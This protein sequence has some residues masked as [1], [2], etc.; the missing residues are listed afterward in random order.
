[1][2]MN[3]VF[4]QEGRNS[5]K[6]RES[7]NLLAYQIS[8]N[9]DLQSKSNIIFIEK[10]INCGAY[11]LDVID[12]ISLELCCVLE[13]KRFGLISFVLSSSSHMDFLKVYAA[14]Y[15]KIMELPSTR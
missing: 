8:S 6:N 1:M 11:W 3:K 2:E 13:G 15:I 14:V 12:S 5:M 9:I 4:E 7:R 10:Q